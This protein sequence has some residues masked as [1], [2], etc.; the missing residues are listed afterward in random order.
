[1]MRRLSAILALTCFIASGTLAAEPE[2]VVAVAAA[3]ASNSPAKA[4]G[5][6]SVYPEAIR[7]D[8]ARDYQSFVAIVK[9]KDDV[10]LDVTDSAKWTVA[11]PNVA[12]IDG[13]RLMPLADGETELV[14]DNGASQV[15]V[16]IKVGSSSEELPISFEK[17]IVDAA[18][19]DSAA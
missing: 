8:T 15:R 11:D 13:N 3:S 4:A 17:D 14:C 2:P 1:M 12:K 9:R 16:P 7:L 10:T 18:E 5:V 6:L 19:T